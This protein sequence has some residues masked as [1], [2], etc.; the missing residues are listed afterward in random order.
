M[1]T[2]LFRSGLGTDVSDCKTYKE[3]I[4]KANLNYTVAKCPIVAKLPFRIENQIDV[5]EEVDSFVKNSNI[6][7]PF[8]NGY[9]VYRTDTNKPL[10]IVKERYTPIQNV[11]AF[12]GIDDLITQGNLTWVSAGAFGF[13]EQIFICAKIT[14]TINIGDIDPVDS[15]LVFSNS[16][17]GT[18]SINILFT[19]IRVKCTN[20]VNG[21]IS[22]ADAYIRFRH[23]ENSVNN[24]NNSMNIIMQAINKLDD[25][26]P[27][28]N[29]LYHKKITDFESIEIIAKTF[30]TKEELNSIIFADKNHWATRLIHNDIDF[31]HDNK[32]S[33]RK[34]NIILNTYEY[35]QTDETQQSIIGTQW[36]VYNS[37]TGYFS[38]I[39]NLTGQKKI[40]SLL[41]GN[42]NKIANKTL[43]MLVEAI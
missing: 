38:N 39:A 8:N 40:N 37:I 18:T 43:N 34:T 41:Y 12:D 7:K 22:Q 35:Y 6:Y 31:L 17:N 19:P 11:D 9:C 2:T 26:S 5:D 15:Y 1:D 23:T 21:A 33:T 25:I 13:G 36:G 20:M 16:H 10:G 28:Y 29:K 24:F 14:K 32:I 27:L 3:V 30:L 42:A 4:E